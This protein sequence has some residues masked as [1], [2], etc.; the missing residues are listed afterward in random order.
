M[1]DIKALLDSKLAQITKDQIFVADD[2]ICIP[3]R[4]SKKEDIEIAG[5]LT[6]ILSWGMRRQIIE[7]AGF[8]MQLMDNAP[9]QFLMQAEA[10]DFSRLEQFQYRTFKGIDCHAL[11]YALAMIYKN[12]GGLEQA[13]SSG[14]VQGNIWDAIVF[15]R[16]ILLSYPHE[17]RTE[18]H[19]ANPEKGASAKRINMFLRWMVRQ[20]ESGIDFGL[21]KNI[22]TK[23]LICPLDLHT[24]NAA[25]KLGLLQRKQD[26]KRAADELT[27]QLLLFDASDPVKYDLALFMLSIDKQLEGL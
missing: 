21:W 7:R 27:A 11:T 3:H 12:Q 13:F 5:F 17:K 8:L 20:D 23:A 16:N 22:S 6:A 25:R 4:F 9:F 19:L 26:D 18:K 24:G 14:F 15:V 2:P 10:R 1:I